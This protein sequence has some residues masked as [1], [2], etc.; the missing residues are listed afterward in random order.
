MSYSIM[1]CRRHIAGLSYNLIFLKQY[2]IDIHAVPVERE[3]EILRVFERD[4]WKE[5]ICLPPVSQAHWGLC[6]VFSI[7]EFAV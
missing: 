4:R 3:F 6:T 1:G 2:N 7:G 5:L